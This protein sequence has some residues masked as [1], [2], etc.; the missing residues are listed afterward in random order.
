MLP[1]KSWKRLSAILK[2]NL[3][4]NFIFCLIWFLTFIFSSLDASQYYVIHRRY[5]GIINTLKRF[6]LSLRSSNYLRGYSLFIT[7]DILLLIW[8]IWNMG[9]IS[10]FQFRPKYLYL[11]T[12]PIPY[13]SFYSWF[14]P[15]TNIPLFLM[16]RSILLYL[17]HSLIILTPSL[18][19]I[20]FPIITTSSA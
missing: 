7:K 9:L 11:L 8:F 3:Q 12:M 19:S 20:Y 5:K 13:I 2:G 6:L 14:L 1:N 4:N 15:R 16:L 17:H 10:P 18:I